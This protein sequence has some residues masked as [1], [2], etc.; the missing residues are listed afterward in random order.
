MPEPIDRFCQAI[1]GHD[2]AV[3][4]CARTLGLDP[5]AVDVDVLRVRLNREVGQVE[6]MMG[7]QMASLIGELT[8]QAEELGQGK[9]L[10]GFAKSADDEPREPLDRLMGI[11]RGI[12]MGIQMAK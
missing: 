3:T 8:S 6:E 4:A 9:W 11:A 2:G 12:A 10:N 7:R 1:A 5:S